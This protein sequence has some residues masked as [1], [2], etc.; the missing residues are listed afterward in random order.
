MDSLVTRRSDA[1]IGYRMCTFLRNLGAHPESLRN[2]HESKNLSISSRLRSIKKSTRTTMEYLLRIKAIVDALVSIGSP[3]PEHEHI[4]SILEGLLEEYC[5]FITS[6]NLRSDN[7]FVFELQALLISEEIE[8]EQHVKPV[9]VAPTVNLATHDSKDKNSNSSNSSKSSQSFN[10]SN[11]NNSRF[12][13]ANNRGGRNNFFRG[14]ARGPGH[15]ASYCYHCY[16]SNYFLND[17]QDLQNNSTG[18]RPSVQFTW[19]PRLLHLIL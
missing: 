15:L 12:H 14:R 10:P 16:D 7:I 4:Q 8:L 11:N 2:T 17:S 3:V 5:P 13:G 19:L 18:P 6:V 1:N 9:V